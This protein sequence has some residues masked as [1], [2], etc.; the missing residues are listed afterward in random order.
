MI[1]SNEHDFG[2]TWSRHTSSAQSPEKSS[3]PQVPGH[4]LNSSEASA[5]LPVHCP[6]TSLCFFT[7]IISSEESLWFPERKV[8]NTSLPLFLCPLQTTVCPQTTEDRSEAHCESILN[9]LPK[10]RCHPGIA[11]IFLCHWSSL[12]ERDKLK[13]LCQ[14]LKSNGKHVPLFRIIIPLYLPLM[15]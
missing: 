12:Q 13:L 2:G 7:P 5:S 15:N 10:T 14:V 11:E 8:F 3:S 1:D 6:A 9:K 4:R